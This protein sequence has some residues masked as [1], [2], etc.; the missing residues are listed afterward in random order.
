[1]SGDLFVFEKAEVAMGAS[2][3]SLLGA[4][5]FVDREHAS[6]IYYKCSIFD[7]LNNAGFQ[8]YWYTNSVIESI[9]S[10][11]QGDSFVRLL[12]SN[13]QHYEDVNVTSE[14]GKHLDIAVLPFVEK[15]METVSGDLS[16]F[17]RFMGSHT[18]YSNR[19]PAS[20]A[21]FR[22]HP[23][24][25]KRP[26]LTPEKKYVIDDYDNTIRYSEHVVAELLEAVKRRGG[27]AFVLY[28]SDHG[29]EVFQT[30]DFAGRLGKQGM[31]ETPAILEIPLI[32]WL[33][34][35][36]KRNFP[37]IAEAARANLHKEFVL[38]DLLWTMTELYGLTF[39]GFRPDRSLVNIDYADRP[40]I[41]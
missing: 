4:F 2:T 32:L 8:T 35:D 13:V 18:Q 12:N 36:Y 15:T 23:D 37:E 29:E 26:W 6:Y 20:F 19:Y 10:F 41:R 30:A 33:S 38:D 7:I 11:T 14:E 1:M 22:D 9:F 17:V 34:D 16:I 5:S 24:D 27:N 39:D 31:A 28:F 3:R 25:P 21:C 40:D